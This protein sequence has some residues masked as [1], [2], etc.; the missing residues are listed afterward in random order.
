M[1]T[2]TKRLAGTLPKEVLAD[3]A[4]AS[5][6]DLQACEKAHVTRYALVKA[7]A[8]GVVKEPPT[9]PVEAT[10]TTAITGEPGSKRQPL[11]MVEAKR[12]KGKARTG[13]G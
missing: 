3:G 8:M 13:G 4:Y 6:A 11:P 5:V 7:A 1:L 2:R 12:A 10:A 9:V